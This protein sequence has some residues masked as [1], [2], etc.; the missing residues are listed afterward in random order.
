MALIY[1]LM[2]ISTLVKVL[3]TWNSFAVARMVVSNG[4]FQACQD[5]VVE[6]ILVT[7]HRC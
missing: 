3:Y 2:N 6:A 4:I 1:D 7:S 5:V